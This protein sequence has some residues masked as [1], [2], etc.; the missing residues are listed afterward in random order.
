MNTVTVYGT[1]E[2]APFTFTCECVF[3]SRYQ[4][5]ETRFLGYFSSNLDCI[6]NS[7]TKVTIYVSIFEYTC[8]KV[9]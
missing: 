7:I 4:H 8:I 5:G 6:K 3:Y 2:M 9:V 1:R